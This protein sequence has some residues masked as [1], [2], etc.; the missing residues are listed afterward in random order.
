MCLREHNKKGGKKRC[1]RKIEI[2][3]TIQIFKT[4]SWQL[5]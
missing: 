3:K 2:A 1:L 4:L 5:Q